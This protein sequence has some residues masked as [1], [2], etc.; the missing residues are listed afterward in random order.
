ME[1][2]SYAIL[3]CK[4][5]EVLPILSFHI[6]EILK[7]IKR[8]ISTRIS[9][10]SSRRILIVEK[11]HLSVFIELYRA[12]RDFR[13]EFG[14]KIEIKRNKKKILTDI[15]ITF[16]HLGTFKYHMLQAVHGKF[17]IDSFIIKHLPAG[18]RGKLVIS[19]EKPF[20]FKYNAL[21]GRLSICGHYQIINRYGNIC[22]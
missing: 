16:H 12:I 21:R 10:R 22:V 4:K 1:L 13:S 7:G 2:N 15:T 18:A 3:H 19:E 17:H 20:V 6:E 11:I 9:V 8:K 14:R 5:T